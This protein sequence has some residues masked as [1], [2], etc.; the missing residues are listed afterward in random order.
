MLWVCFFCL[1]ALSY[2]LGTLV[3]GFKMSNE[4]QTYLW[5][6]LYLLLC[7]SVAIFMM[8]VVYDIWGEA[9]SRRILPLMIF[10]TGGIFFITLYWPSSFLVF[11]IYESVIFFFV[12][13]GYIWLACQGYLEGAWLMAVG[14]FVALIAAVLQTSKSFSFT[15]IWSFD[16]NGVFHLVQMVAIVLILSGLRKSLLPRD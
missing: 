2:I 6:P 15:F 7:L 11:I 16:H 1:M 9:L 14:T 5:Y 12:L 4:L 10:I 13:G 3:H 8:A